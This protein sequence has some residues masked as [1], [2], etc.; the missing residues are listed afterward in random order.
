MQSISAT[1]L[2]AR[3]QENSEGTILLDVREPYEYAYAHIPKALNVPFSE[4]SSKIE[5]LKKYAAVYVLC[6]IGKKSASICDVLLKHGIKAVNVEG[7]L[8]AWRAAGFT[9]AGKNI[10]GIPL[11]TR[12]LLLL[13]WNRL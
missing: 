4:I 8:E 11:K 2:N 12:L 10:R 9:L 7:G 6:T 13:P 5:R 1:E 3:L